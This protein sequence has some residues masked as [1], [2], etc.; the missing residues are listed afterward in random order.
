MA[1]FEQRHISL[2][3]AKAAKE[4]MLT[5]SSLPVMPVLLWDDTTIG[6]GEVSAPAG[7]QS[8][9]QAF[10]SPGM[11]ADMRRCLWTCLYL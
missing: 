1:G 4:V 11:F 7:A 9:S 10:C 5:S 2:E 8:E 3:E 6:A